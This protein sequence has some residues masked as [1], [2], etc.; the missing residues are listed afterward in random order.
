[1]S[2]YTKST[3]FTAKDTS[4]AVVLGAE[5]DAEYNAIATAIATKANKVTGATNGNLASLSASGDLQ[6]SG[7]AATQISTNASN[8]STL[9]TKVP[10]WPVVNDPVAASATAEATQA[11]AGTAEEVTVLFASISNSG[12]SP[13]RLRLG[14]SSTPQTTGYAGVLDADGVHLTSTDSFELTHSAS[15]S[16]YAG[17]GAIHMVHLGS[18]KWQVDGLIHYS[19]SPYV[20]IISGTVT[21][22]GAL[23]I[24]SLSVASGALVSTWQVNTIRSA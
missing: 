24:V 14:T 8:I 4:H 12:S 7:V 3:N 17:Q 5:H 11:V 15:T 9:E 21:L 18:N 23:D 13:I 10:V 20:G 16:A 19:S 2:D 22:S 1:M 6:D